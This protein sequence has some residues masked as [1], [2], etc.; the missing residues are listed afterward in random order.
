VEETDSSW[1]MGLPVSQS[2]CGEREGLASWHANW[3]FLSFP[4]AFRA[5]DM[6]LME[7]E[8]ER[9]CCIRDGKGK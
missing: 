4:K 3:P 7:K 9:R 1:P 2:N 5:G 6:G 8:L